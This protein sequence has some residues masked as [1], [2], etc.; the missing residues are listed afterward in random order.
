MGESGVIPF[1]VPSII[2]I[3]AVTVQFLNLTGFSSKLFLSQPAIFAFPASNSPLHSATGDAS[4]FSGST[5]LENTTPKP[6]HMPENKYWDSKPL[7]QRLFST[8]LSCP[9]ALVQLTRAN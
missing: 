1:L 4:R 8:A 6:K 3:V 2:S 7:F 5:K 9:K